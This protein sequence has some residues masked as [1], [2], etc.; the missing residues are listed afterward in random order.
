[1]FD[2]LFPVEWAGRRATVSFPGRVDLSNTSQLRDRLQA[3]IRRGAALLVADMSG[4]ASCDHAAV[5]V[6]A[7]AC[8]QAAINGTQVR[9][10]V[11]A[12]VVRRVLSLEGLDRLVAIFPSTEAAAAGAVPGDP[13]P[14]SPPAAGAVTAGAPGDGG[15]G[16]I[17]PAILWNLLDALGDG[18]LL[19]GPD[20]KV[21]LVNRRCAEMLGYSREELVGLPVDALLPLD[22]RAAH[23]GYRTAYQQAP[24][25]RPMAER[26]R[27]V[28]LRRDGATLPVEITLSPVPTATE[29]FVL[30]VIRDVS[31]NPGRQDDL[32]SLAR[33][34]VGDQSQ[35]TRDLLDRVMHRLLQVGLTLQAAGDLPAEAART[36]LGEALDQLDDAIL[37]IRDY[38]FASAGGDAGPSAPLRAG[39]SISLAATRA[40]NLRTVAAAIR[41]RTARSSAWPTRPSGGRYT[42][43][44]SSTEP[45]PDPGAGVSVRLASSTGNRPPPGPAASQR[46]AIPAER[47]AQ[48]SSRACTRTSLDTPATPTRAVAYASSDAPN[49]APSSLSRS[50]RSRATAKPTSRRTSSPTNILVFHPPPGRGGEGLWSPASRT[51]AP[52]MVGRTTASA[53]PGR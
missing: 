10:V 30:A 47:S 9:L 21:A 45:A 51:E 14:G 27:L 41:R 33:G 5:E 4:T 11:T 39:W 24:D 22:V 52:V 23:H 49:R 18:L 13:G 32:V 34:A 36:R 35:A 38:T 26:A 50:S 29:T 7:R 20:G 40:R 15:S 48:D 25:H 8:Q 2:D 17:T 1:M 31:G 43:A 53:A 6:I 44:S 28:A 16:R 12:P 42:P 46:S 19:S 37:Q 3:V